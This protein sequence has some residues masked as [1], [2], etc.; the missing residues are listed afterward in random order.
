MFE[1][2]TLQMNTFGRQDN[3]YNCNILI[4]KLTYEINR[5]SKLCTQLGAFWLAFRKIYRPV[6]M[7]SVHP[8][9]QLQYT[10]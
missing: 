1:V 5:G 9:P 8:T 7:L 2:L 3:Y 6:G 10:P 4:F